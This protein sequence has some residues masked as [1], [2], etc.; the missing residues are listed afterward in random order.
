MR[1]KIEREDKKLTVYRLDE[2]DRVHVILTNSEA[3]LFIPESD[4]LALYYYG[5]YI[6][7]IPYVVAEGESHI[8]FCLQKEFEATIGT[9]DETL[10][11]N[12]AP[13]ILLQKNI[14][15]SIGDMLA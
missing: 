2:A 10:L 9:T 8:L 14:M 15:G 6:L 1:F 4:G 7:K 12:S 3:A 13:L 5:Q 11:D